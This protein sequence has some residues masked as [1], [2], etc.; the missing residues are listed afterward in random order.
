MRPAGIIAG[1]G[2]LVVAIA[3]LVAVLLTRGGPEP[4]PPKGASTSPTASPT[5]SRPPPRARFQLVQ[6]ASASGSRHPKHRK[7]RMRARATALHVRGV[8][9]RVYTYGFLD[10]RRGHSS[11]L[12]RLFVGEARTKARRRSQVVTIGSRARELRN[13]RQQFGRLRVRT[14]FSPQNHPTASIAI[15]RFRA[16]GRLRGGDKLVVRS[17]GRFFLRPGKQGWRVYGFEITRRDGKRR[18]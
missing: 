16:S 4:T 15:A 14:L 5:K 7:V 3:V 8:I 11:R 6:L 9:E 12:L 2:V 18:G 1:A 17:V 13:L 10:T